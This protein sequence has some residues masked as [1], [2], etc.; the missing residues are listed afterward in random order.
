MPFDLST[1]LRSRR[2]ALGL[3]QDV[4]AK[5]AGLTQANYSLIEQGK[6]DPRYATLSDIARALSLEIVLVP[7]ELVEVVRS[8][9]DADSGSREKR[10]L[11]EAEPD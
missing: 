4:A 3:T 9:V 10:P 6:S 2:R 7:T 11:F 8:I 1:N 5:K